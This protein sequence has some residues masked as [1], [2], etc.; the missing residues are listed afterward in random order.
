[1]AQQTGSVSPPRSHEGRVAVVTGGARGF[2]RAI[3]VG[4]AARGCD[5]AVVDLAPA[6]ETVEAI[7]DAGAKGLSVVADITDPDQTA[8]AARAVL[9]RF[10]HVDILVNNAGVIAIADFW[11]TDYAQWR[12][13][14]A[15]NLDS[16]F[17]VTKEFAGS[18]REHGWG[19]IVNIASNTLGLVAP[20]LTSYMASKGGV[21]GF[22]RALATDLA[23]H[24]ITVN[25]VA[26]TATTTPGGT[27][28]IAPEALAYSA[29]QQAI[30]RVG[31]ADD[32]V[33]TVCFLTSDDA[34]FMTGQTLVT[35]G[36][37][38]RV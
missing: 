6:A 22:T 17:L 4:L 2:G 8:A 20:Q 3:A 30:K 23:E 25:A 26:P 5:V 10:G 31:S 11:A 36:G 12:K 21:V 7:T 19:R 9:G 28:N 27:E 37:W 33:G 14:L 35:D 29:A 24:G 32:I 1:M 38:M 34:A 13:V 15:I 18:M 16:Q